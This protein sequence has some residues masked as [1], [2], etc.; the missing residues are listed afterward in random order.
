MASLNI[1]SETTPN[2]DTLDGAVTVLISFFYNVA[3]LRNNFY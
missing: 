3:S 1:R 2:G